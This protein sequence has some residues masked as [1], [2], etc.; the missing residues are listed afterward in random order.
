MIQKEQVERVFN[1]PGTVVLEHNQINVDYFAE[2][3]SSLRMTGLPGSASEW[4]FLDPLSRNPHLRILPTGH[5]VFYG[6][7]GRRFLCTDPS[8]TP[9]HECEWIPD[10]SGMFKMARARVQLDSGQWVGIQSEATEQS[11]SLELPVQHKGQEQSPDELRHMAARAWGVP[12][13]DIQYFYPDESFQQENSWHVKVHL[14][15]DGLYFLEDGS[16]EHRRFVSYMGAM[17]WSRIDLLNVVELYQSTF[18]GTGG[19]VFDLIWGLCDDQRSTDGSIPLRYRGLPTFPSDQAYGLFCAF[20]RPEVPAGEDAYTLFMDTLRGHEIAWWP[21]SDPPWR[22]FDQA[23]GLC[24]TVQ[25]GV[26]Q[27]VTVKDDPVGVPYLNPGM[28]GFASCN[29]TVN[30]AGQM[31]QLQDGEQT[32]DIPLSSKWGVKKPSPHPNRHVHSYPFDWRSFFGGSPPRVDPARAWT[33][34]L[35]F[36]NDDSEVAEESTQLFVLEQAFGFLNQ[37][38]DLD[39]RLKGIHRMLIHNF[40]PVCAGFVDPDNRPRSYTILYTRPE[41]AQKN[42]QVIWDRAARE[43]RLH[44]VQ[45][46]AFVDEQAHDSPVYK[47]RYQLIVRWLPYDHYDNPSA[48]E[49]AITRLA[50]A[51]TPNGLAFLTGPPSLPSS[52]TAKGFHL[53]ATGDSND[54]AQWP[55]MI[56]HLRLHPNTQINPQLTAILC[57]HKNEGAP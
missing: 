31:M 22:Y 35:I 25:N 38:S 40:D 37:L 52:L 30:I 46:V 42:A 8:G 7:H 54:L 57:E 33:T 18:P 29:R 32:T 16:F 36:P 20:F 43:G 3:A 56:E 27:K 17:P 39:S 28:K 14:R 48:C 26:V 50:H 41:W 4:H 49:A 6:I 44:A 15:K 11:S 13:E 55:A 19:A 51:L 34:A 5:L 10:N 24:V 53:L 45:H 23:H 12:V 9:L 47:T 21:R 2:H 1:K